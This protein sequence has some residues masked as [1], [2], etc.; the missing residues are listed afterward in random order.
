[1]TSSSAERASFATI[2][3]LLSSFVT[4]SLVRAIFLPLQCSDCVGIAVVLN[5]PVSS[6]PATDCISYSEGDILAIIVLKHVPIFKHDSSDPRGKEVGLL[7]PL[8]M[9]PLVLVTVTQEDSD[10]NEERSRNDLV[11]SVQEALSTPG[12][13]I[14]PTTSLKQMKDPLVLWKTFALSIDLDPTMRADISDELASSVEWQA[15][16]YDHPP[17]APTL[18]SP[19]IDWEQSIVEGHPTYPM[20]K[21]RRF[22]AP[23]P[24]LT[25]GNYDLYS[26]RLRLAIFPRASLRIT[27]DFE[28][29]VQPILEGA[30]KNA[31]RALEVPE[32]HVVVPVHELQVSHI[33]DKFEEAKVCPE[34][35]SVPAR[36]QQSIRSVIIP[37]ILHATLLKLGVGIKLTSAVRIIRPASP[38]F[39]PRFSAQVVPALH[40]DPS[41]LT[42]ARELASIVHVAPDSDVAGHCAAIVRECHENGSEARGERLIVC[43][44]LVEHGHAGTDGVTPSVVR[45]FGLD[46]EEKRV[47]WLDNF[48]RL[49]FAAFLPP[50]LEDGVAFEAHPQNTVAR[51]SLAAPHELRGFMIRD[52]GGL[53]VHPP[54]LLKSTGVALDVVPGHSI[55][56]DTLDDVY[57]HTYRTVFHN[58]LQRLVRVLGLHHNGKGWQVIR[59]RLREAIPPGHA[60]ERAWLGKEAKTLEG[61]CPMRMRMVGMYRYHLNGPFPNLLHYT[62]VDEERFVVD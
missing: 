6:V 53:R 18:L 38:Y 24:S 61:K 52:F 22:L 23:M 15:H 33:L 51:F 27:G 59:T 37:D 13:S 7:D 10:E 49:F 17:N 46:T 3:R 60:L 62:G 31:G 19:S 58:H 56:A 28:A 32:N 47:E 29:L 4:E 1:M 36:A 21:M 35:F 5:A 12:W 54:T 9:S 48:V 8:D 11:S 34:E 55:V 40:F 41:L 43:T 14:S 25:P 20:H 45:V 16:S 30:M 50:V 42:V 39:G 26:P 2:A 57:M 44:S